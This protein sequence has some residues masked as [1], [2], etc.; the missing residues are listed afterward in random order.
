MWCLY[1]KLMTEVEVEVRKDI[2]SNGYTSFLRS[3]MNNDVLSETETVINDDV[4]LSIKKK[5]YTPE[6]EYLK[7]FTTYSVTIEFAEVVISSLPCTS[8]R[9][10]RSYDIIQ[11]K[12][13]VEILIDGARNELANEIGPDV[14]IND[15]ILNKDIARFFFFD[16]EQIV[17]LAETGSVCERR[18]LCS[19]YNEVLGVRKYEDLKKNLENIR[20]R[21]RRK[22]SDIE[23]RE[24]LQKLLDCQK[25]LESSI[26]AN[27]ENTDIIESE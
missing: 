10:S 26:D 18:K 20:L 9:I 24:K 5:G 6:T 21:F 1:G 17:A 2:N 8:I 4:R 7:I 15:F 27:K 22:S 16:S 19:A 3:N 13:S 12:E 11:D 25:T 14:F 23:G